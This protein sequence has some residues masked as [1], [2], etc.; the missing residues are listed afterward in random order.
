[1]NLF[2][3][4]ARNYKYRQDYELTQ[5]K[6]FWEF[7]FWHYLVIIN[8]MLAVKNLWGL[9]FERYIVIFSVLSVDFK[10]LKCCIGE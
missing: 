10:K 6:L 9:T 2:P 1:M 3:G 4:D 8:Q 7:Y 5:Q